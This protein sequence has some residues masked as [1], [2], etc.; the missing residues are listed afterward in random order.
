MKPPRCQMPVAQTDLQVLFALTPGTSLAGW[1]RQGTLKRELLPAYNLIERGARVTI[2]QWLLD[3]VPAGLSAFDVIRMPH[4][5]LLRLRER[6]PDQFMRQVDILRTNQSTR[7]EHL[8]RLAERWNKPIALR[9]GYVRGQQLETLNGLTKIVRQYHQVEGWA[10][11]NATLVQVTANHLAEWVIERY[12]VPARKVRVVPNFVDTERFRPAATPPPEPVIISVGRLHPT[13]RYELAIE[14]CHL[15][16][17]LEL[18]LAGQGGEHAMLVEKARQLDVPLTLVGQ[19]DYDRLPDFLQQAAVFVITSKTEGHP[20]ALV[21][22]M[23][24]GLPCVCVDV[25]GVRQV[26]QHEHNALLVEPFPEAVAAGIRRLLDDT[27]LRRQLGNNAR[28][29][30]LENFDKQRILALD[31]EVINEAYRLSTTY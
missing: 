2:L 7:A 28:T 3:P 20:K 27:D 9:C 30:A 16:G 11:R 13:K 17:N 22:A 14:A 5:R 25:M 29:F 31:V 24:C 26:V 6:L 12:K 4:W 23:A 1:A 19:I 21:E 8:V 15:A 10:F 18:R